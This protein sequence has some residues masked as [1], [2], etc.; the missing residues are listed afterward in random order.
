ML[1]RTAKGWF[2]GYNSNVAGHEEG[3][4]RYLVFNGGTPKYRTLIEQVVDEGYDGIE[5]TP[6]TRASHRI[7]TDAAD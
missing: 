1:L 6:D 4:Y 3:H 5:L 2:T 7:D